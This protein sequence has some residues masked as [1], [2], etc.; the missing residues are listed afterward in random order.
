MVGCDCEWFPAPRIPL[1]M[2]LCLALKPFAGSVFSRRRLPPC[3]PRPHAVDADILT[4]GGLP[5]GLRRYLRAGGTLTSRRLASLWH[6]R[7]PLLH[8]T[9]PL[10]QLEPVGRSRM[11]TRLQLLLC[12]AA[13]TQLPR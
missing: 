1:S 5:R 7:R 9:V 6:R 8:G 2:P 11:P 3:E 4:P 10:S 13:L 12:R